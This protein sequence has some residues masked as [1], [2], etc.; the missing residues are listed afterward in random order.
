MNRVHRH[1]IFLPVTD[2]S[3]KSIKFYFLGDDK[4]IKGKKS[5]QEIKA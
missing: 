3:K 5:K 4:K 2:N 1:S